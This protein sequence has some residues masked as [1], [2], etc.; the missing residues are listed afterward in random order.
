MPSTIDANGQ[1]LTAA[2]FIGLYHTARNLAP[3]RFLTLRLHSTR[4]AELEAAAAV[5]EVVHLGLTPGPL[6]KKVLRVQC[7]PAPEGVSDGIA[8]VSDDKMEPTKLS[9]EIHGIEE[10]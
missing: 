4:L 6:G 1:S 5:P 10:I 8:V 2:F 9:I 3:A 7:V